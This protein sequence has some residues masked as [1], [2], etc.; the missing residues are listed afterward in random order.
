MKDY[1]KELNEMYQQLNKM[2]R[3]YNLIAAVAAGDPGDFPSVLN[4]VW[5]E[6]D[7]RWLLAKAQVKNLVESH[8]NFAA[9]LD[10]YLN[11]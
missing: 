9:T 1:V 2:F 5:D 11:D 7:S 8:E 10:Q 6:M 3:S 4:E